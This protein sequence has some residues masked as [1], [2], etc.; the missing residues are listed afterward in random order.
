MVVASSATVLAET[1]AGFESVGRVF[2]AG[3]ATIGF[4][5]AAVAS[6]AGPS[7]T[8]VR[9]AVVVVGLAV[10]SVLVLACIGEVFGAMG[11]SATAAGAVAVATAGVLSVV[12]AALGAV[13]VVVAVAAISVV[14][15]DVSD[16]SVAVAASRVAALSPVRVR[17]L[18]APAFLGPCAPAASVGLVARPLA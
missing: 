2:P 9:V 14:V 5:S 17:S 7:P 3:A 4:F 1:P 15:G 11:A 16:V 6:V 8:A 12:L 13:V 18:S 10:A